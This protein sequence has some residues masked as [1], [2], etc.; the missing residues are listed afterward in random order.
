MA[1]PLKLKEFLAFLGLLAPWD[2]AAEWDNVG[3]MV[4]NPQQTITGLLVALDPTLAVVEEARKK[5]INTILTHHPLIFQPL[6][7]IHTN[8]PTGRII[9]LAIKNDIAIISAHTNL[10]STEGGV[11][12][13]LAESLG[14]TNI[15]TIPDHN[16]GTGPGLSRI[17]SLDP[18]M[19]GPDFLQRTADTLAMDRLAIA[20]PLPSRV[21]QVAVCG[22][23]GSDLAPAA[24][25]AGA[26]IFISGEIKHSTARWAE[27]NGFCI[28]DGGHWATENIIVPRLTKQ[29]RQFF[30]TNNHDLPVLSSSCQTNPFSYFNRTSPGS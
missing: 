14:L 15:T 24:R 6:K 28:V 30:T 16:D 1:T 3:L 2:Y 22:G 10:D 5:Q 19:T 26:D 8:H 13:T 11:N 18:G 21:R 29:I 12:D 23:S 27:G 20:G 9:D 7:N 17:G 4:G 25:A